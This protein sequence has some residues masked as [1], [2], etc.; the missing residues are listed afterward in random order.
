VEKRRRGEERKE[1]Q[2]KNSFS[3]IV[4]KNSKQVIRNMPGKIEAKKEKKRKEKKRKEKKRKEKKGDKKKK[5][6]EKNG[7]GGGKEGKG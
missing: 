1:M 2:R 6:R 4:T 3:H 7:D 5:K